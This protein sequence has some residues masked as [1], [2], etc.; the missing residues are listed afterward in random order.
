MKLPKD[1]ASMAFVF[2]ILFV[3]IKGFNIGEFFASIF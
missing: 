1:I 3:L 2:L